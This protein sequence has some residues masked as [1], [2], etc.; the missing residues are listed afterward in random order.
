MSEKFTCAWCISLWRR[1]CLPL[2]CQNF[3]LGN[4]NVVGAASRC[5][6]PADDE[7]TKLGHVP[8]PFCSGW[9]RD[10]FGILSGATGSYA[11]TK[12]APF[13]VK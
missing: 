6:R 2:V 1:L 7:S 9:L 10:A 3:G 4:V 8:L 11:P 5:T 12:F 13:P